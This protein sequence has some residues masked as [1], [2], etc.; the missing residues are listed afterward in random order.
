[1]PLLRL[2]LP[3]LLAGLSGAGFAQIPEDAPPPM[4]APTSESA[5]PDA[6]P[7]PVMEAPLPIAAQPLPE[8]HVQAPTPIP[9]PTALPTPAQAPLPVPVPA[10]MPAPA[11]PVATLANAADAASTETGDRFARER[12]L[13]PRP[14]VLK[15]N[16]AFWRRVF[17]EYSE[18]QS[19]I[20]DQRRPERIYAVLDFRAD[21]VALPRFQF[22]AFKNSEEIAAKARFASALRAT[23]ALV[24]RPEAMSAEQRRLA[25]LFSGDLHALAGAADSIRTQRGLRE[26][27]R[28]AI[29]ISGQYLPEMERIFADA[30][31]P[32]LLTRLPIV[33]SSFNIN[34]YSKV[35]AAGLWQFMPSSARLYMRHNQVADER[36][37]PW[38]STRAA[39]AHL[40]DDYDA[41][42]SWPLAL[43]AYNFGR[44]GV[45]RALRES[46]SRSLEEILVRY[47]GP[48]FGFASRNF[49]AE[50]VAAT[51]VER[52]YKKIFG[53]IPRKAPV[54][55]ETVTVARYTPYRTL[56]Q[57]AGVDDE[58]FRELNPAYHDEVLRG[59][60]Y[61]PAGDT[62]RLPMG[63]ATAFRAAYARLDDSETFASQRQTHFGHKVKKG[64]TLSAIARRYGVSTATL[65]AAN[66]LKKDA[67]R[68]GRS[69]RIPSDGNAAAPVE[70]AETRSVSSRASS[71]ASRPKARMHKVTSGQTL[72]SIAARYKVSIAAL[73]QYNDLPRS[74][75]IKPGMRL[76]IPS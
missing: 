43:T 23:A 28:E 1:M 73:K 62:I 54:R 67:L 4:L 32:R 72:T 17:A 34:A 44:G 75:L 55:F 46:G 13:F 58:R 49:Y 30:G 12:L 18:N 52:D 21:A 61:V 70:R 66:G 6:A 50:F 53:D 74:G 60:L 40:S 41:L 63:K 31:L 39:A 14:E 16:I 35:A 9:I 29:N 15:P 69:I 68:A 36:R 10:Q 48:R 51:D 22:A 37:D 20:H 25:A 8:V 76:K 26:R 57:V 27:T 64:E 24:N 7:V 19:V 65:R 59:R 33:E 56:V 5:A 2:L 45:A 11:R 38:T 3:L 42:G 71:K 47:D